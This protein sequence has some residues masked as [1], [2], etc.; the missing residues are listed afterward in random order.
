[1]SI[2]QEPSGLYSLKLRTK[3]KLS[4][5]DFLYFQLATFGVFFVSFIFN[6]YIL[7]ASVATFLQ[8][9]TIRQLSLYNVQNVLIQIIITTQLWNV[10]ALFFLNIIV[11]VAIA[12]LRQLEVVP[13]FAACIIAL[14]IAFFSYHGLL[15][16][17][18]TRT[19]MFTEYT[20]TQAL[21]NEL[22]SGN[23]DMNSVLF[24]IFYLQIY[25]K[26]P[27]N[28]I[29]YIL[30]VFAAK[31]FRPDYYL[32][33]LDYLFIFIIYVVLQWILVA[34]MVKPCECVEKPTIE[35]EEVS[36]FTYG[37]GSE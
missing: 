5:R 28:P 17:Y 14:S 33:S 37:L 32:F 20:S 1:M 34:K 10:I 36:R 35:S 9:P 15:W 25:A 3:Q 21:V 26:D 6:V 18:F 11:C 29:N 23:G 16:A 12:R 24:G 4:I 31:M 7:N 19:A 22:L 13:T 27:S 8:S 30:I 2:E